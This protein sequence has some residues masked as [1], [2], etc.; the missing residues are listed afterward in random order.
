[1]Y[2]DRNKYINMF[3]FDLAVPFFQ[4]EPSVL[5]SALPFLIFTCQG[6]KATCVCVCVC[7]LCP[8]IMKHP[9]L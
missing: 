1:M 4:V 9:S 5:N 7:H 8:C 2:I 3:Y 6:A